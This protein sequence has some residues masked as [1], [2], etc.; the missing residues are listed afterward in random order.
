VGDRILFTVLLM[1]SENEGG[2]KGSIV[3]RSEERVLDSWRYC[4]DT[5]LGICLI[6]QCGGTASKYFG[7]KL[8]V[9]TQDE[10]AK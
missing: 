2:Y 7:A 10:E 9:D 6:E 1:M 8:N 5:S 4:L 3:M